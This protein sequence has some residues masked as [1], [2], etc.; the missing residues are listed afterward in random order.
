MP[1]CVTVFLCD[2]L[3]LIGSISLRSFA[4]GKWRIETMKQ[5]QKPIKYE[6]GFL[7]SE[8]GLLPKQRDH[9][10]DILCS[11]YACPFTTPLING[12]GVVNLY[13]F[14]SLLEE[15]WRLLLQK[16]CRFKRAKWL[17]S[18]FIT[19]TI[20]ED[21]WFYVIALEIETMM[22]QVF[23]SILHSSQ[24][25]QHIGFQVEWF[26]VMPNR[27]ELL[28]PVHLI[29]IKVRHRNGFET[30]NQNVMNS[31]VFRHGYVAPV[32]ELRRHQLDQN[33]I[34]S[35]EYQI[36]QASSMRS[37]RQFRFQVPHHL[38]S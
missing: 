19:N 18:C 7:F 14:D 38:L 8:V 11:P 25:Q 35:H 15:Q 21:D 30:S 6:Q 17:C 20:R 32:I 9:V 29:K 13:C 16:Y 33:G 28:F 24:Y 31:T 34:G 23:N 37:N 1:K 3:V 36:G 5:S 27:R 26:V 4:D 22:S 2:N 10:I 12:L